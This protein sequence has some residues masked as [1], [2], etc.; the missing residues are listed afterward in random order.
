MR[1]FNK[2]FQLLL[3]FVV[4][5]QNFAKKEEEK[6]CNAEPYTLLYIATIS[7]LNAKKLVFRVK[8]TSCFCVCLCVFHDL[9]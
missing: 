3:L 5:W 1:I 6:K 9:Y 7:F 2:K 4:R 8:P